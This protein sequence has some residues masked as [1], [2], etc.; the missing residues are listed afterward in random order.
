[1]EK[2]KSCEERIGSEFKDRLEQVTSAVA[3]LNNENEQE[4]DELNESILSLDA[5]VVIDLKLSWGG[6]EDGFMFYIDPDGQ[7]QS[8]EI[9]GIEYYFRDWFDGATVNL[10]GKEFEA[11]EQMWG[12]LVLASY[13][14][15]I[16]R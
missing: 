10:E 2:Q 15:S 6:P 13:M 3:K 9:T 11:I 12:E 1:M 16:L 4:Y 7:C 8:G 5:T 14:D